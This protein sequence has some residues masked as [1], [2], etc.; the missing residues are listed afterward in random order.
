MS[1]LTLLSQ[2]KDFG[3]TLELEGESIK[4]SP[5]SKLTPDLVSELKK[6]KREIIDYLTNTNSFRAL[7]CAV[8]EMQTES[9]KTDLTHKII[10]GRPPGT[11]TVTAVTLEQ[12]TLNQLMLLEALAWSGQYEGKPV[13]ELKTHL[14][15][16]FERGDEGALPPLLAY[17]ER[18]D[19]QEILR[20]LN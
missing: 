16:Y 13:E 3:I 14:W 15:R 20:K 18:E 4:A 19:V 7:D 10:R 12:E 11:Q 8:K 9:E 5:K 1:A 17:L 6:H 2:C